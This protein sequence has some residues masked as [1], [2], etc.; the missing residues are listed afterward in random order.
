LIKVNGLQV[1][2]TELEDLLMTHSNIADAAV[3]GLADEHF[4]QVPTAF[5]V[6]KDPNGKDSLPE[7]IEEYVKGKLP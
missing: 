1:A 3:I 2:P 5:V 7:D 4:G 6:L